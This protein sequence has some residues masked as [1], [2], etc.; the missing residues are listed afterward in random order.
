[1][2]YVVS[3]VHI[4]SFQITR[5]RSANTMIL[6]RGLLSTEGKK[7]AHY[8]SSFILLNSILYPQVSSI[9]SKEGS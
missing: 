1:M 8:A 5:S 2:D 7:K 4:F 9:A 6:G 3:S